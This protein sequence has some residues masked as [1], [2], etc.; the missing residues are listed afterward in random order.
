MSKRKL[1]EKKRPP[2]MILG[3]AFATSKRK[4]EAARGLRVRNVVVMAVVKDDCRPE[5]PREAGRCFVATQSDDPRSGA[6]Q[7]T[8]KQSATLRS[9][10]A[11]AAVAKHTQPL[12]AFSLFVKQTKF[13]VSRRCCGVEVC[14]K[15]NT[16]PDQRTVI[17]L[18]GLVNTASYSHN[19]NPYS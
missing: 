8:I 1:D 15:T 18:R 16:D 4:R 5:A 17:G 13:V 19:P 7:S 9:V 6:R 11:M 12:G 14:L 10:L 3:D 2:G